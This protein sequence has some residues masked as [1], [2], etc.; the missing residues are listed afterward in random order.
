MLANESSPHHSQQVFLPKPVSSAHGME[1]EYL[2]SVMGSSTSLFG[3]HCQMPRLEAKAAMK[4]LLKGLRE[5]GT[6]VQGSVLQ[7]GSFKGMKIAM[8]GHVPGGVR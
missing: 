6:M 5:V 8:A 7:I 3:F 4:G 2:V 1:G